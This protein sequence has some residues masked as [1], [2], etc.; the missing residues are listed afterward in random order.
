[1]NRRA[2]ASGLAAAAALSSV[3][4]THPPALTAQVARPDWHAP[5]SHA[6]VSH[7][8]ELEVP[9][10]GVSSARG[11]EMPR[12]P[13][14]PDRVVGAALVAGVGSFAG[15]YVGA[16]MAY[17]ASPDSYDN[18]SLVF[19]A[20]VGSWLGAAVGSMSVQGNPP[21]ALL[22]SAG[23]VIFGGMAAFLA[24]PYNDGASLFVYSLV[25]G[26]VTALAGSGR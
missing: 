10:P 20:A 16:M 5:V 11:F 3:A 21:E 19:G 6:P 24:G 14:H 2:L 17:N 15:I 22:G 25:H 9:A 8:L 12:H 4:A 26:I 23:G 13:E 7:A 18:R 1:M